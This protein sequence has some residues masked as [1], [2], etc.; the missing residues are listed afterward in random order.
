MQ[1]TDEK[2]L[3]EAC[4]SNKRE[5]QRQLYDRYAPLMM[6]VA[7]RYVGDYDVAQDVLQEAFIKVFSSLHTFSAT[8]SLEG[9]IRRI[10]INSA[11][12]YLRTNDILH[13]SVELEEIALSATTT[14]TVIDN[15]SADELLATIATL[16]SGFRTV[17][18]MFAIEG[19]SH[20]EIAQQL[21]VT[22]S[23][24]RSQY[25]RAKALL[26]K[27]LENMK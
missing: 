20:K 25:N 23:T 17:F 6:A 19:Y 13:E 16:P 7:Q 11:L 12:E 21:G 1:P 10:V 26:K 2:E 27:K 9:W 15:I 24:S 4:I 3:I 18:N 8:G 22:E 14:E 5:A